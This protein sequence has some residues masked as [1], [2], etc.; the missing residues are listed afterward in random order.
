[1]AD[2]VFILCVRLLVLLFHLFQIPVDDSGIVHL[3]GHQYGQVS[4][5][6]D[7]CPK[8]EITFR[9][10]FLQLLDLVQ[11]AV[12]CPRDDHCQDR[13]DDP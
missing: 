4:Q 11:L 13:R 12:D 3:F 10:C 2:V 1:M 6:V 8:Q 5:L 7:L 9:L